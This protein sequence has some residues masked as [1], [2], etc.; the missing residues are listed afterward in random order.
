MVIYNFMC[1]ENCDGGL[2]IGLEVGV[3]YNFD[4][5]L[6]FGVQVNYIYVDSKDD[7]VL[8]INLLLVV[9]F[10]SG[11]EGFVKNLYNLIVFYDKDV[12]QVW[13]VY[14]WCDLFLSSCLGDGIQFEYND[15]YGQLDVSV[16]YDINE[17]FMVLLEVVNLI[18]E[19]CL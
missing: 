4:F 3:L 10:G 7:S 13:V 16:L 14:N 6:G 11:L 2:V 12:F 18:N 9:E 8:L 5:L 17:I 15:V 1:K 19:M